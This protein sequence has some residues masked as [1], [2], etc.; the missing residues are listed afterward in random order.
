MSLS[1]YIVTI[2]N[3]DIIMEVSET[4][5]GTI[6]IVDTS[7]AQVTVMGGVPGP[8]GEPGAA[9]SGFSFVQSTPSVTWIIN[10]NLGFNP[11]IDL[12][13]IG[14][15]EM[16]GEVVHTSINQIIVNFNEAI[17]GFARLN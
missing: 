1:T 15:M 2:N 9:G 13:S 16:L 4:S 5:F 3:Q 7:I 6:Q 17:A 10:H 12:F 11:S 8:Q 14:G